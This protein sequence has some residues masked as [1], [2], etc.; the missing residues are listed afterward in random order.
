MVLEFL[1]ALLEG[2]LLVV[3]GAA[4]DGLH[5]AVV[6]VVFREVGV[7]GPYHLEEIKVCKGYILHLAQQEERDRLDTRRCGKRTFV[8]VVALADALNIMK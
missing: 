2:D 1:I 8:S 3:D 6:S 5:Y 4:V 7:V